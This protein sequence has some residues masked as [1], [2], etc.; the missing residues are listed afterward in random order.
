MGR[1]A[2]RHGEG[3]ASRWGESL[4][5]SLVR[6]TLVCVSDQGRLDRAVQ[7]NAHWYDALC[8]THGIPGERHPGYWIS[9]GT[10]LPYMSNLITLAGAA[11]AEAQWAAIRSMIEVDGKLH[12]SVKDAFQC[13]DLGSLG[14]EVL[15][16]ATWIYLAA[17]P[18]LPDD[19]GALKWSIVRSPAELAEW[20]RTWRGTKASADARGHA[21]IFLPSLLRDPDLHFLL[22]KRGNTSLATAALN[23][24][25]DS[26]G[27]SN[28]FSDAESVGP[29]FPGAVRLATQL[30][31]TLPIVGYEREAGLIDA[32]RA[33]F[34][35][36]QGLTVWRRS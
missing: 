14:F 11:H 25:G 31:P 8:R 13:L 9:R 19:V 12:F 36:L 29:L 17:R 18:R 33:G 6:V 24:S 4:I 10:M 26:V 7:N 28:V 2:L 15:F 5:A 23:R 20:E 1:P 27:I 16:Q 32:E 35:L 21:P 34:E 30:H 22:G 3:V